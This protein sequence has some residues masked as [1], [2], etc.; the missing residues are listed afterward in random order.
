MGVIAIAVVAQLRQ[1]YGVIQIGPMGNTRR[2]W[3]I[4]RSDNDGITSRGKLDTSGITCQTGGVTGLTLASE[5]QSDRGQCISEGTN[6]L[7]G[8]THVAIAGT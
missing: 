5:S 6:E 2:Y 1:P 8:L 4:R 7:A 3:V